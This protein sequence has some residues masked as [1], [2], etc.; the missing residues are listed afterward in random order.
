[1]IYNPQSTF[2]F[3]I[4]AQLN[5]TIMDISQIII[6]V[7]I[8]LVAL[9]YIKR[10]ASCLVKILLTIAVFAALAWLYF[11]MHADALH[12]LLH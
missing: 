11:S 9:Y 4:F 2:F 5:K 6:S 8:F 10:M 3:V 7:I 12:S 1:M